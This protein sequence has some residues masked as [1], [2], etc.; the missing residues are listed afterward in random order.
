MTRAIC[1]SLCNMKLKVI[2]L[3]SKLPRSR[4]SDLF[5]DW[6]R[7]CLVNLADEGDDSFVSG[8]GMMTLLVDVEPGHLCLQGNKLRAPAGEHDVGTRLLEH[9]V[10]LS[11]LEIV[12]HVRIIPNQVLD[13]LFV[14]WRGLLR[15][16]AD[17]DKARL[18]Q[19]RHHRPRLD[20]ACEQQNPLA[21]KM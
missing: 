11:R 9:L 1:V 19:G 12:K 10:H 14:V 16:G 20:S 8:V 21:G 2:A 17:D 3:L 4:P 15:A 7:Q 13:A 5:P 18:L 6:V